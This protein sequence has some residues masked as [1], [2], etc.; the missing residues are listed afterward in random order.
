[1]LKNKSSRS[2]QTFNSDERVPEKASDSPAFFN[3]FVEK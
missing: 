1:M 2:L 3:F